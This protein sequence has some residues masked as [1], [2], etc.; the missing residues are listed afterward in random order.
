[1][2]SQILSSSTKPAPGLTMPGCSSLTRNTLLRSQLS[3]SQQEHGAER[4]VLDKRSYHPHTVCVTI[5]TNWELIFI[6][7]QLRSNHWAPPVQVWPPMTR[8]LHRARASNSSIQNSTLCLLHVKPAFLSD[9]STLDKHL[10]P[11]L[12]SLQIFLLNSPK[13]SFSPG[14]NQ[15]PGS[16]PSFAANSRNE[17]RVPL[18]TQRLPPKLKLSK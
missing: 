4:S 11:R 17:A 16:P 12:G 6:W 3:L 10:S 2:F 18:F 1:M 14:P 13:I 5:L 9:S 8:C 7:H 15:M